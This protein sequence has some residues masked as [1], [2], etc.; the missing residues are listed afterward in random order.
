MRE[1]LQDPGIYVVIG[2][3]AFFLGY[4]IGR[5][6]GRGEGFLEGV[7]LAPLEMRRQMWEKGRCVLCGALPQSSAEERA[8]EG[9]DEAG[10]TRPTT[11]SEAA[12]TPAPGPPVHPAT[13]ET[14]ASEPTRGGTVGEEPRD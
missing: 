4:A 12:G 8:A 7:R 10:D 3:F 13:A 5:R 6:Q 2:F 11:G 9:A 1:L 14:A